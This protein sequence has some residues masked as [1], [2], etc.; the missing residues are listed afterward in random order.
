MVHKSESVLNKELEDARHKVIVDGIYSHFKDSGK[1]YRVIGLG[2]QEATEKICVI[3]KAEYN[4]ELVFIRD[5]DSWLEKTETDVKR[6][7]LVE[8]D[9]HDEI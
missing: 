9:E 1:R 5:L 2:I 3:Y 6:F 4:S 7:S 8:D